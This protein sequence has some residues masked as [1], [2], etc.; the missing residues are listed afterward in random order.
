MIK[1]AIETIDDILEIPHSGM[2]PFVGIPLDEFKGDPRNILKTPFD[3]QTQ[4]LI[5]EAITLILKGKYQCIEPKGK[6]RKSLIEKISEGNIEVAEKFCSLRDNIF[7]KCFSGKRPNE[8]PIHNRDEYKNAIIDLAYKNGI[9]QYNKAVFESY[10][11]DAMI[12]DRFREALMNMNFRGFKSNLWER[13]NDMVAFVDRLKYKER[14]AEK[15]CRKLASLIVKCLEW[16]QMC[17]KSSSNEKFVVVYDDMMVTDNEGIL[18]ANT[19]DEEVALSIFMENFEIIE[20]KSDIEGGRLNKQTKFFNPEGR[21]LDFHNYNMGF[22]GR[23]GRYVSG[24]W[25]SNEFFLRKLTIKEINRIVKHRI[26][27]NFKGVPHE[28]Y[29]QWKQRG[30]YEKGEKLGIDLEKIYNNLLAVVNGLLC[31]CYF[32]SINRSAARLYAAATP[33][34]KDLD[35]IVNKL[36]LKKTARAIRESPETCR[37]QYPRT[38]SKNV[39]A[40][41]VREECNELINSYGLAIEG[42][43]KKAVEE[44]ID[45]KAVEEIIDEKAVEEIIDEKA[46]EESSKKKYNVFNL[47]R[48]DARELVKDAMV[49]VGI[50]D[51]VFGKEEFNYGKERIF[52]TIKRIEYLVGLYAPLETELRTA[53]KNGKLEDYAAWIR[54]MD[55]LKHPFDS[56]ESDPKTKIEM[57]KL[58]VKGCLSLIDNPGVNLGANGK[59]IFLQRCKR[60]LLNMEVIYS[61]NS[62]ILSEQYQ[63]EI[64][65]MKEK[66]DK[67][68]SS[69]KH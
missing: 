27:R 19:S 55:C 49:A 53:E 45:E 30:L 18:I 61:K 63:K 52:D 67:Y 65:I 35:D 26:G 33:P 16:R 42:L 22:I 11:D 8:K 57:Y 54:K 25:F 69:L 50:S 43:R 2:N 32:P 20:S 60:S 36:R 66:V 21:F 48:R 12:R 15:E 59:R 10:R 28:T 40:S 64:E 24:G 58:S 44:I 56:E 4:E 68:I 41:K 5:T 3:Q 23:D 37:K 34:G 38:L 46:V 17:R 39:D 51:G 31:E 9:Y 1:M 14:L 47:L 62:E 13:R 29:I 6:K 7:R